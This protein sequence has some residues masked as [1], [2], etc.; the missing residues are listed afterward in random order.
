MNV[1]FISPGYPPEMPWFVRG[2][3]RVGAGVIGI[4]DLW[5]LRPEVHCKGSD[6]L[7]GVPEEQTA[8]ILAA[9]LAALIGTLLFARLHGTTSRRW[10]NSRSTTPAP[11][12]SCRGAAPA[13]RAYSSPSEKFLRSL[14]R[15]HDGAHGFGLWRR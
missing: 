6:Y 13:P 3:A 4:G 5:R 7:G 14:G 11:P 2:L 1:I 9:L 12:T 10:A 8:R 15:S